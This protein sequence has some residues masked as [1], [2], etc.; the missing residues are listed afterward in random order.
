MMR[1]L[2]ETIDAVL[3]GERPDYEE[4]RYAVVA[5]NALSSFNKKVIMN[6]A[7]AE[8][9]GHNRTLRF[10]A[11]FQ[12]R[13]M[14]ERHKRALNS[15]ASKW[16]GWDHDPDN[17]DYHARRASLKKLADKFRQKNLAVGSVVAPVWPPTGGGSLVVYGEFDPPTSLRKES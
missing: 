2:G 7:E 5:L 10:S 13:E 17:P 15:P 9:E 14:F 6:L 1:T 12:H 11:E 8:R 16:I 3:D 4:L